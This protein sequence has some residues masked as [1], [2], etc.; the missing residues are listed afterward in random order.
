VIIDKVSRLFPAL[1]TAPL[2]TR[3]QKW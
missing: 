2:T 1:H 3:I